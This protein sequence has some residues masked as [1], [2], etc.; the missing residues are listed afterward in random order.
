MEGRQRA[1]RERD[2]STVDYVYPWADGIVR[3]EAPRDRCR[4]KPAPSQRI[5]PSSM[6]TV[7][8]PHGALHYEPTAV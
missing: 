7:R 5:M 4:L 1:F 3:H 6:T 8:P 2:L